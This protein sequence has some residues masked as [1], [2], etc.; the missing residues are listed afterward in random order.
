V[1][2]SIGA[3]EHCVMPIYQTVIDVLLGE[4]RLE[5][6]FQIGG[7]PRPV[8]VYTMAHNGRDV[9]VANP[10]VGAPF[11]A[12]ILEVLIALGCR[13]FVAC[14]GAGVLK[15]ELARGTIIIPSSAVRDE[16]TSY[17]Y[18]PPSKVI[19]LDSD[20]V[21]TLES[22]L[23]RHGEHYDVGKTWTTDAFFRETRSRVAERKAEGCLTV[24]MECSALAAVAKFRGVIFGQY[25]VAADDVSGEDWD[26]RRTDNEVSLKERSFWLAVE[27][28][29]EL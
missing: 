13:K 25:L 27:A 19:D 23:R 29:L 1:Y 17:H 21:K 20:V 7:E 14:G 16:G 11:A 10:G 24:D 28:C 26:R 15:P 12:A 9:V 4:D 8:P 5:E 18:C 6:I 3:P 22:V 2:H